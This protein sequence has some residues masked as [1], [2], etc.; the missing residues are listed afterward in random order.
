MP[1]QHCLRKIR[2]RQSFAV[3]QVTLGSHLLFIAIASVALTWLPPSAVAATGNDAIGSDDF[4]L[5]T[6]D[7]PSTTRL[8]TVWV[9]SEAG[10]LVSSMD[11]YVG[12]RCDLV[13]PA[14]GTEHSSATDMFALL[15]N[16]DLILVGDL[17]TVSSTGDS[18]DSYDVVVSA[19]CRLGLL[20]W[21][22]LVRISVVGHRHVKGPQ[23]MV[24]PPGVSFRQPAYEG[25]I[26]E[27][28]AAGT[29]VEGLRSIGAVINFRGVELRDT[30]STAA[31]NCR[32]LVHNTT[33]DVAEHDHVT[34][35]TL[36]NRSSSSQL[37]AM[38]TSGARSTT[39]GALPEFNRLWPDQHRTQKRKVTVCYSVI[40]G[41]AGVFQLGANEDGTVSL[42]TLIPL[43]FE[44]Q[45]QYSLTIRAEL[46]S[47]GSSGSQTS[48]FA[49]VRIFVDNVNDNAPRMDAAE[50]H[51]RFDDVDQPL[52]VHPTAY[53]RDNDKLSFTLDD[54]EDGD[55]CGTRFYEID[56]TNGKLAVRSLSTSGSQSTGFLQQC[57]FRV[58]ADD[59]VHRS[60]PALVTVERPKRGP[61]AAVLTAKSRRDVRPLRQVEIP[62]NMIGDVLDL[63]EGVVGVG[64]L[65]RHQH[66]FYAFKDPAP[67]QLELNALTGKIK[68][69]P[70]EQ[71][72]YET[73]PEIN[74][75]VVVT[76]IDDASGESCL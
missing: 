23:A 51:I 59:G 21:R 22:E 45:S 41:P 43:D 68:V 30:V 62:E 69:R 15:A 73:Q 5:L 7:L 66:E 14:V 54:L 3:D 1:S 16:G 29:T 44:R 71:L 27:N 12:Q 74:F 53:D 48:A 17:S 57:S 67:T 25:R 42:R 36:N 4:D 24:S 26:E 8:A 35:T 61:R 28:C 38:P 70:G 58:F 13:P 64:G 32:L 63:D 34:H 20:V 2:C 55:Y 40:S 11:S 75:N 9:G 76:R 72:D 65:S 49:H 60:E 31:V 50:Y 6:D 10:T 33:P 56:P 46:D 39:D 19:V 37:F 52:T 18:T 47:T